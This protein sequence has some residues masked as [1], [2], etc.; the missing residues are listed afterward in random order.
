MMT[1][2]EQMYGERSVGGFR[3]TVMSCTKHISDVTAG[4]E[5]S[6]LGP[7]AGRLSRRSALR[8]AVRNLAA[9]VA[10]SLVPV[11]LHA[12]KAAQ[13]ADSERIL[14]GY[15]TVCDTTIQ[16]LHHAK[17]ASPPPRPPHGHQ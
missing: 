9:A 3:N 14:R 6:S 7:K 2:T 12:T 11:P 16:Y 10:L 17:N 13:D 1:P 5:A 15:E 8:T 4:L